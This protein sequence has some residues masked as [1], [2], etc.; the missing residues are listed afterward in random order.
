MLLRD[1]II[2]LDEVEIVEYGLENLGSSLFGMMITLAVG[3]CFDFLFESFLLWLLLFPLRKNAGG[4]HAKTKGRCLLFSTTILLVSIIC[5]VQVGCSEAIYSLTAVLSFLVIFLMAPVE[6]DNKLLDQAEYRV[7][8][9]RTR[10]ILFVE[11][12]LFI[13]AVS[14]GWKEL[15]VVLTI[16]FFVVGTS[17]IAGKMKSSY[18]EI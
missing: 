12:I 8:R 4:F 17:L 1:G 18:R 7:Y 2:S 10:V 5:F 6:N 16:V 15:I 11:G 9:K 14:F 3:F 13:L